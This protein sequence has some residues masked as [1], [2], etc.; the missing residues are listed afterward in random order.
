MVQGYKMDL[1]VLKWGY[2]HHIN[3]ASHRGWTQ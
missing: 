3:Q 2:N 1:L